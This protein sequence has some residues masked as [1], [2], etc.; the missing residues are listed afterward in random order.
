MTVKSKFSLAK[1]W[2][3]MLRLDLRREQFPSFHVLITHA[4]NFDIKIIDMYYH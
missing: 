2:L 3:R 4:Q 1:E